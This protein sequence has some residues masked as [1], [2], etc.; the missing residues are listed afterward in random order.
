[1]KSGNNTIFFVVL[2]FAAS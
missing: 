1:M 2:A